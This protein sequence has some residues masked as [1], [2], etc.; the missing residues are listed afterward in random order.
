VLCKFSFHDV[1]LGIVEETKQEGKVLA[2]EEASDDAE[3]AGMC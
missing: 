3:S 2:D 1:E